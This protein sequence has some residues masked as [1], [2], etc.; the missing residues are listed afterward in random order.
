M[1]FAGAFALAL[2]GESSR[3]RTLADELEKRFPEDT[4]VQFS[5]LPTLRALLALSAHEPMTAVQRLQAASRYD[6]A[7]TGIGFNGH[8][9]AL[10]SVYVRGLA[11]LAAQ[12]P[13]EAAQ[14]FRKILAHRHLVLGDP[15]DAMARL[16]LARALASTGDPVKAKAAYQDFLSLWKAADTD[17]SLLRQVN[18]EYARLR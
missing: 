13:A 18:A 2:A 14:E 10:Y 7:V 17:S 4:S 8:Y 15:M 1:Q 11:H 6:L 9:G 12:Q 3:S 16:Q 5:Y